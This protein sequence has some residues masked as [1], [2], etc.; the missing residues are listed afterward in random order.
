MKTLTNEQNVVV[1]SRIKQGYDFVGYFKNIS[2]IGTFDVALIKNKHRI[3]VNSCGY[4]SYVPGINYEEI[5]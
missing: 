3:H 1:N 5:K 4:D 2:G